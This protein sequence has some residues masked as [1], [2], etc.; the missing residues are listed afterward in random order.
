MIS[1]IYNGEIYYINNLEDFRDVMPDSVYEAMKQYFDSVVEPMQEEIDDLTEE[2][3]DLFN[4]SCVTIRQK[5]TTDNTANS[6]P[7]SQTN[8]ADFR[9]YIRRILAKD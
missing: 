3:C 5:S 8:D 1:C 6:T 4:E 9:N 7:N 2:I